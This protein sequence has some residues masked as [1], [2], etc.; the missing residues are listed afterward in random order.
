MTIFALV[1]GGVTFFVG[2]DGAAPVDIGELPIVVFLKDAV[3]ERF[4]RDRW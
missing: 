1:G 2:G 4:C 3:E